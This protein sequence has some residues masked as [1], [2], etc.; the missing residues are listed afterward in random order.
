MLFFE[1]KKLYRMPALRQVLPA[2]DYA[3]PL[4]QARVHRPGRDVTVVA[5]GA[6]VH[7]AQQAAD[8]LAGEGIDVEILDLRTLIPLDEDTIVESVRK[9]GRLLVAH[10]DT[11]TAG[12]AGEIALRVSERAFEWL[13]APILRVTAIDAPVPYAAE[14]EDYFLPHAADIV[15]AARYLA[16]Y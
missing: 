5:Y 11:R 10:E 2:E 1:H 3:I 6:M 7:E 12:F 15:A 4:G 14:L 9:T 16:A 13:D 8:A